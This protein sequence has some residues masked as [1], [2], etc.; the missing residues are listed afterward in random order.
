MEEIWIESESGKV[1]G[2]TAGDGPLV[3]GLHGW[4][5]RN[6]WHTW[7]PLLA[8]LAA[9]GFRA[10]S[11]DMPGWGKSPSP[12]SGKLT[13][14]G[15]IEVVVALLEALGADKATLMGKSWGGGVALRVA[16]TYPGL[17]EKLIL[18]AP[19]FRDFERLRVLDAPVL[20]AWARND[21]VIPVRFAREYVERVPDIRLELYETGGHSAAPKNV[22][23]F[24]PAAIE[25]LRPLGGYI[26]REAN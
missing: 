5:E 26:D 17:V 19:A 12:P 4:S 21:N 20:L 16:F 11:V 24:A 22:E 18:S 3:L 7:E 14:D 25:F 9:A 2:R 13:T 10:V 1:Y 15:A 6:G 23:A 8:P